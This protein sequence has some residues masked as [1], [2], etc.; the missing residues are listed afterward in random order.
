M[1][2]FTVK[3]VRK[4]VISRYNEA[5]VKIA[6]ETTEIPVVF[7]DL[8]EKAAVAYR[9]KFPDAKVEI[10]RQ[11]EGVSYGG[12]VSIGGRSTYSSRKREKD[13]SAEPAPVVRD[14]TTE[15]AESGDFSAA[16]DAAFQEITS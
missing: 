7:H 1:P 2:L 5:G 16:I 4:Q 13:Y 10:E 11:I 8:P 12:A 9:T 3:M 6:E 15:A 14:R